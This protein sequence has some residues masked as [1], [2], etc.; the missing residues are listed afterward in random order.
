MDELHS[1]LKRQL[2]KNL[3]NEQQFSDDYK[4]LLQAVNGAYCE[5]DYDRAMLE[6]SLELSSQELL[7]ANSQMLKV[8]E[9]AL[10]IESRT[11]LD[12]VLRF[13]VDSAKEL[14]GIRF[15]MV[16][17]LD[18]SRQYVIAPYYS[19][20]Q[21]QLL[22][23]ALNALGFNI[24]EQLGKSPTSKK[25]QIPV[26]KLKVAQEYIANPRVIVK[27]TLTELLDGVWPKIICETIQKFWNLKKCIIAPLLID[28]KSWGNLLFFTDSH[29]SQDILE[30]ISA[31]C[32]LGIKNVLMIESLKESNQ[33]LGSANKQLHQASISLKKQKEFIDRI[34]AATPNAVVVVNRDMN[35]LLT[36]RAFYTIFGTG[37]NEGKSLFN[38]I[39]ADEI[40]EPIS[41]AM[42]ATGES[43]VHEF[44][45]KIH[46]HERIFSAAILQMG[47]DEILLSLSDVTVE[48]DHQERLYLTDRLASVGEMAAGI[49]HEL[50][51]PLTG[52]IGLSDFLLKQEI[53]DETK[54]DLKCISSEAHRAAEIVKNLLTFARKHPSLKRETQINPILEDV[55][56]LRSHQHKV[57]N[58]TVVTCLDKELP[59]TMADQF[60]MQQVFLNIILNAEQA[61][62]EAH[63]RGKL[64]INTEHIDNMARLSFSDDGP[65]ITPE[66]MR[67]LFSP[68]FT[69]KEVGKGTGLGMSICYGIV[70]NHNG[71]IYARS[72]PGKGATFIVELPCS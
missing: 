67:K 14:S 68:F 66:N 25:F 52:I 24:Y 69:T 13:V 27:D 63:Q 12:D 53:Q 10:G 4:N 1:L 70:S 9:I 65:G 29:I 51:N 21:N 30:M 45:H 7:R 54:Q 60:Q 48:R 64:T 16:Q 17:K 61:M 26:S 39:P 2:R 71:K 57:N 72:E 35:I 40:S 62:I 20:I 59:K 11:T 3:N 41:R 34:L 15:V 36:N 23:K 58:I 19:R 49:A 43:I 5:F 32:S 37:E 55:L 18:E 46:N 22:V 47:Q 38:T 31:H 33:E 56:K 6:R 28:G 50:N 42:A 44:R 8:R